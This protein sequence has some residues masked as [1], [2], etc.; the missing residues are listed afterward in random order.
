MWPVH[1]LLCGARLLREQTGLE[2]LLYRQSYSWLRMANP[3]LLQYAIWALNIAE[4][5]P[6]VVN[7]VWYVLT[8][9]NN[10]Q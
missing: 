2:E 9:A 4:L 3:I 1:R 5:G 8:F 10:P 6:N 7:R